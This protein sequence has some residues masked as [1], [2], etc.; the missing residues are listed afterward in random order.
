MLFPNVFASTFNLFLHNK[1]VRSRLW[2]RTYEITHRMSFSSEI[3]TAGLRRR[4]LSLLLAEQMV[5]NRHQVLLP[6]LGEGSHRRALSLPV[7]PDGQ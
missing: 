2:P 5:R 3:R 6:D 1:K 7:A 4:L